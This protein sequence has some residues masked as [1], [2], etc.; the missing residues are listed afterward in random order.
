MAFLDPKSSVINVTYEMSNKNKFAYINVPKASI[1]ALSKNS[2]NS[3]PNSFARNV[4]T[5]L[6]MT[7]KRVLKAVSHSLQGDIDAGRH[8]KIGLHKNGEYYYSN[9]FEYFY[10]N[11]R[12]VYDSIINFYIRYS[13]S[14]IVTVHD[15]KMVLKH[16]GPNTHIISIPYNNY[17]N[18]VDDV[19]AQLAELDGEL[20]YCLLDCGIFGLG[21][22]PKVWKNLNMSIIDFGK[23]LSISKNNNK[24]KVS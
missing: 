18:K 23:T 11:D 4:V 12:E 14:A 17:Y 20:D 16:F 10:L 15:K 1:V 2:E 8:Y 5:S 6:K 19:Y 13:K 21:L 3:F 7:D 9:I 24:H 22:L